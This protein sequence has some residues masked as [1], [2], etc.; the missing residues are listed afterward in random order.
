LSAVNADNEGLNS[1]PPAA[2]TNLPGSSDE[3]RWNG[4]PLL[5]AAAAA[6]VVAHDGKSKWLVG[7]TILDESASEFKF[8]IAS[9]R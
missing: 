2:S 3:E 4:S 9:G 6:A 1:L 5:A 7:G 8:L